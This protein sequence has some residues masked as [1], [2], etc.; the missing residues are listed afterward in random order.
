ML[1]VG[2]LV[3]L[4]VSVHLLWSVCAPGWSTGSASLWAAAASGLW[5]S[6]SLSSPYWSCSA[7]TFTMSARQSDRKRFFRWRQQQLRLPGSASGAN[8]DKNNRI[9]PQFWHQQLVSMLL[10]KISFGVTMVTEVGGGFYSI[11]MVLFFLLL[12]FWMMIQVILLF[13]YNKNRQLDLNN[14]N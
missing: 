4:C 11:S 8:G 1:L 13:C 12:C 5:D 3:C 7:P 6:A 9:S 2:F 10:F 14:V